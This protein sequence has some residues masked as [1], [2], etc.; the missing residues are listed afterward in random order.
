MLIAYFVS[1][2]RIQANEGRS[3]D[4]FYYLVLKHL[5]QCLKHRKC[6]IKY[7]LNEF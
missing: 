1:F 7:F 3:F 6:G 2:A 4:Q 5:Y